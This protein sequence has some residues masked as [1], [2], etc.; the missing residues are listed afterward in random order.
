MKL[1]IYN[2][3]TNN[4]VAD[5]YIDTIEKAFACAGYATEKISTLE[6]RPKG[7]DDCVLVVAVKDATEAKRK[8]YA[9]V[10]LWVQGIIPEESYMRN[11]SRLRSF[12]FSVIE[13]RGIKDADF[14]FLVSHAMHKHFLAKYKVDLKNYYVMPCFNAQIEPERFDH[15]GKYES[16][17]FLY[18]GGLDAWQCFDETVAL[19]KRIES[20]VPNAALRVLTKNKDAALETIN[21]HGVKNYS[22]DFR[23]LDAMPEELEAAKFGFSLR[24][25]HPVNHVS[26][27]TKLSSYVSCGVI[28]IYS[29]HVCDFAGRAKDMTYA[30][31]ADPENDYG[32]EKIVTL[33]N[34]SIDSGDVVAEFTDKFGEY[35][36]KDYHIN[37]IAEILGKR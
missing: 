14:V 9:R 26:T 31:A 13:K 10:F 6:K 3:Y 15:T 37:R 23:P 33:C 19:Y 16:N 21:R 5:D 28:P 20:A 11:H 22:I 25:S 27:P 4:T 7:N 32:F 8:G 17:L 30:V 2:P 12:V 24:K 1:Y 34:K 18:A 35:Y 29:R 36:S